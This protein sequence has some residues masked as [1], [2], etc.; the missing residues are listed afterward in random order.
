MSS[1]IWMRSA[2]EGGYIAVVAGGIIRW[3]CGGSSCTSRAV[4]RFRAARFGRTSGSGRAAV[5][6]ES[7]DG[8]AP[9]RRC[10]V[11]RQA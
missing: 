3:P 4:G 7:K 5:S 9:A 2:I 6:S 10:N 1:V 8:R 11:S